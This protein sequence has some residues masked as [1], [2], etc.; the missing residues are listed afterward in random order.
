M[1]SSASIEVEFRVSEAIEGEVIPILGKS[2]EG[3]GVNVNE[4][5]VESFICHG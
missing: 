5:E 2:C 4:D 1:D 3:N